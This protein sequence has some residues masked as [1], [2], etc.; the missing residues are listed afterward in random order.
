ME[1]GL[2]KKIGISKR[3]LI[4]IAKED[5]KN[6]GPARLGRD[7]ITNALYRNIEKGL[8]QVFI[9]G[10]EIKDLEVLKKEDVQGKTWSIVASDLSEELRSKLAYLKTEA[11]QLKKELNELAELSKSKLNGKNLARFVYLR[12]RIFSFP[13]QIYFES[14]HLDNDASNGLVHEAE[15]I[16][17]K[18]LDAVAA[19]EKNQ[20]SYYPSFSHLIAHFEKRLQ[21]FLELTGNNIIQKDGSLR[22]D[23]ETQSNKEEQEIREWYLEQNLAEILSSLRPE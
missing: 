7:R 23:T 20:V 22:T 5:K 18:L 10:E 11:L 13:M 21:I 3:R 2:V 9:D 16:S 15:R 14:R 19:I 17:E 8:V 1:G 12:Y 6:R 4:E